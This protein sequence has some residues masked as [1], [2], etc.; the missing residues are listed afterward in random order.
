MTAEAQTVVSYLETRDLTVLY[1]LEEK[2]NFHK[3]SKPIVYKQKLKKKTVQKKNLTRQ[4]WFFL[5]KTRKN[6][7]LENNWNKKVKLEQYCKCFIRKKPGDVLISSL[8][9]ATTHN[10]FWKIRAYNRFDST[11]YVWSKLR[12]SG[13]NGQISKLNY[14]WWKKNGCKRKDSNPENSQKNWDL[15]M[16]FLQS[17]RMDTVESIN[18]MIFWSYSNDQTFNYLMFEGY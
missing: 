11:T 2:K 1:K 6:E 15:K 8:I 10:K 17:D 7:T 9:T 4:R 5:D 14:N 16:Q 13:N 12:K 3:N 18:M